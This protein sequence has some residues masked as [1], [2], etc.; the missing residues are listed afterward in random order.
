MTTLKTLQATTGLSPA[1]AR[2]WIAALVLACSTVSACGPTSNMLHSRSG[3][4]MVIQQSAY[5][6]EGC[7]QNLEAEAQR[8]GMQLRSTDVKG[9][10]F[11]DS[12]LW[13]FVK[14]YVCIGTDHVVPFGI[15]GNPYLYQG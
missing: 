4:P 11:G 7:L 8:I 5:S 6:E 13:P 15:V 10:F 3:E 9:S 1:L 2:G 14:G 12:L